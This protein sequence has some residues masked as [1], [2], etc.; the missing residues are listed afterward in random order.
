MSASIIQT[1]SVTGNGNLAVTL[2]G[3]PVVGNHLIV[4]ISAY[5]NTSITSVTDNQATG[6]NTYQKDAE[7]G[8]GTPGADAIVSS[9][10]SC[11]VTKASG[12]FTLTV[13]VGTTGHTV[14]CSVAERNDL[15]TTTWFDKSGTNSHVGATQSTVTA[16]SANANPASVVAAV[17]TLDGSSSNA[18][19]SDPPSGY[20]DSIGVQNDVNTFVGSEAAE[21]EVSAT[22][23]SACTWSSTLTGITQ[24]T[25]ALA[26]YKRQIRVGTL[27]STL[28]PVTLSGGGAVSVTGTATPTLGALSL[29][30]AGT[31]VTNHFGLMVELKLAGIWV[32]VSSDLMGGYQC[33]RGIFGY[34]PNDLVSPPGT[35]DFALNNSASNSAHTRGYY[36]LTHTSKRANFDLGIG[37]RAT[38]TM[39][40]GSSFRIHTGTLDMALPDAGLWNS[41]EVKCTSVDWLGLAAISRVNSIPTQINKSE[42]DLVALIVA[43]SVTA[44]DATSLDT[45]QDTYA[46]S[47]D[48][49]DDQ[50]VFALTELQRIAQ[51]ARAFVYMKGDGTL[52]LET[53]KNRVNTS[54]NVDD[55]S[56]VTSFSDVSVA[57]TRNAII[58]RFKVTI[59]P[60]RV[61][62]A[63]TTVLLQFA[64]AI[65]LKG[66]QSYTVTANYVDPTQQAAKIGATNIQALTPST[67]YMMN[68]A[69]DGSSTD[70][71]ASLSI[72]VTAGGNSAEFVLTNTGL[73]D[74]F[75]TL[76]QMRGQG[77]YDYQQLNALA[78]DSASQVLYGRHESTLDLIYQTSLVLGQ[79]IALY[80]IALRKDPRAQ[81]VGATFTVPRSNSVLMKRLLTL[82]VSSRIGLTEQVT[83]ISNTDPITGGSIGHFVNG[84]VIQGDERDNWMVD[85]VLAP[86]ST[87]LAWSLAVHGRSELGGGG[88]QGTCLLGYGGLSS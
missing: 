25:A 7:V 50:T 82:D 38:L 87:A 42:S 44:P 84:I 64:S 6:G 60:R 20:S 13:N 35:F 4:H 40:D 74:G 19:I 2:T 86:A 11:H 28:G 75:V 22:E 31:V 68:A 55:F 27:T 56:D 47:L 79:N 12:T 72:V 65:P 33:R 73:V 15:D 45:G 61:D 34:G 30:A 80:E 78:E 63:A 83:G 77:I 49:T 71:T 76:L 59:H 37:V 29:S 51:S 32:D 43:N 26:T 67:D 36:S 23:T 8:I 41:F 21:K 54:T 1:K 81:V 57:P 70:L 48:S 85:F 14:V 17:T 88:A 9:I 39:R 69:A 18:A 52:R 16:G 3:T 10:F 66:G 46:Y 24:W 62:A 58:N 53:R 5:S